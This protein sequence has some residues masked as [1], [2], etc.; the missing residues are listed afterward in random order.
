MELDDLRRQWRQPEPPAVPAALSMAELR[1][2]LAQQSGSIVAQLRRNARLEMGINYSILVVSL[3]IAG[4]APVLWV[5]LFG[6]LLALIAVVC[7]FYFRRKLGLL[8]SMSDPGGDLRAY[9][10]R[11]TIGLR[12]LI[13]FYYRLTL[14]TLPVSCLLMGFMALTTTNK[15]VTTTKIWIVSAVLA[16]LCGVLYLP[17]AHTTKRYLHWLYGQHLDRLE[18]QLRELNDEP[19]A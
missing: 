14:A 19:E 3:L 4:L 7:I 18:G 15:T 16:V 13:Q 10:L 9:L 2:L 11:L 17:T 5:R 12:T 1:Q 8:R 6:G